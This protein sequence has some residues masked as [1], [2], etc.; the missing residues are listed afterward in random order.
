MTRTERSPSLSGEEARSQLYALLHR[1][2]PTKK[3]IDEV[4]EI[5]AN[6]LDVSH[7]HI[8]EIDEDENRWEVIGSSDAPEGPYPAGLTSK[9]SD[10]TAVGQ[11][12][13][14]HHLRY[15]TPATK[16][17]PTTTRTS[18]TS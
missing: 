11:F 12:K 17:G 10:R 13:R 4:I 16:G 2:I 5:G 15:T 18:S 3:A 8:T 6:Y 14:R 9:L 7:G 1:S